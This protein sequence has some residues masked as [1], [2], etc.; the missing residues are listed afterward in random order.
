MRR[1][2][3]LYPQD[4][5]LNYDEFGDLD[6]LAKQPDFN[7]LVSRLSRHHPFALVS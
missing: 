7:H 4:K 5:L 2:P 6:S 3:L 1:S